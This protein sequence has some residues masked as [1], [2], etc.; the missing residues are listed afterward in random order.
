MEEGEVGEETELLWE[1]PGEVG[2]VEVDAGDDGEVGIVR[3]GGAIDAEVGAHVGAN[4]VARQVLRVG[5]DG[6]ALPRLQR[7][8]GVSQPRVR[9]LEARVH[10]Q[11]HTAALHGLVLSLIHPKHSNS[12][13]QEE[14]DEAGNEEEELDRGH[15]I[16]PRSPCTLR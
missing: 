4:P 1:V 14:E 7:N 13:R 9:E 16:S 5:E 12:S 8:V 10:R 11:A 3:G 6:G 15:L 2:V